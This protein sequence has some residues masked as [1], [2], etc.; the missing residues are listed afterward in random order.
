MNG[1]VTFRGPISLDCISQQ[2]EIIEGWLIYTTA[3]PSDSVSVDVAIE[4]F[5]YV[6][7]L[8][9]ENQENEAIKH[10]SLLQNFIY[11][12]QPYL[13]SFDGD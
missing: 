12:R 4:T 8:L 2:V 11:V 9:F 1:S 7:W 13:N 5:V 3:L 6:Q 10:L